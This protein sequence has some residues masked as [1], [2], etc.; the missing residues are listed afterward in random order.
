[1]RRQTYNLYVIRQDFISRTV[2]LN[3]SQ[4]ALRSLKIEA[5]Q[6]SSTDFPIF[7]PFNFYHEQLIDLE[8]SLNPEDGPFRQ[9]GNVRS[10]Q[11]GYAKSRQQES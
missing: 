8:L 2:S 1:M 5:K 6:H 3:C 9:R 7:F 4:C 10:W 11:S